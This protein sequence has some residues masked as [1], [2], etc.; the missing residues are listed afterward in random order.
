MAKAAGAMMG[1]ILMRQRWN[2]ENVILLVLVVP[3]M[4]KVTVCHVKLI[5]SYKMG[6]VYV[7]MTHIMMKIA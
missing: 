6:H 2:V 4:G 3:E 7:G 1:S 5:K